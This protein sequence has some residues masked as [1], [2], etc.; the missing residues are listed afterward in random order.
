MR[1]WPFQ[2]NVAPRSQIVFVSPIES[3]PKYPSAEL[4][5]IIDAKPDENDAQLTSEADKY[6]GNGWPMIDLGY[7]PVPNQDSRLFPLVLLKNATVPT[8]GPGGTAS[9]T[10]EDSSGWQ[11]GESKQAG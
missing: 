6:P 10:L 3:L 4:E 5:N 9:L 11:I 8:G 2:N 7:E 1:L